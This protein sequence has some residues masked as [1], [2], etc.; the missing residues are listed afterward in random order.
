MSTRRSGRAKAPVKYTSDSDG[1]DFGNKKSKKSTSAAP[2]KRTKTEQEPSAADPPKKRTKKDPE[3]VAAE[4]REKAN[5]TDAKAE[6]TRHQK[7]WETWL[8]AHDADGEL[9]DDEPVKEESITQTDAVKKYGIKKEELSSLK[10]FE[11]R[12]PVYNN[13]MKLY[14]EVDVKELGFRKLGMLD[15]VDDEKEA[16]ERGEEIWTAE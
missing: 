5:A 10:H 2:K 11:K 13:T 3:V 6:K 12:N 15:G 14:L 4:Q 9:L 7:V 16:V 8:G 1:S